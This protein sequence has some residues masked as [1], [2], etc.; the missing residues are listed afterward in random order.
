V[1]I[2]RSVFLVFASVALLLLAPAAA[3]QAPSA[4]ASAAIGPPPALVAFVPSALAT[5]SASPSA[6]AAPK[7]TPP[8]PSASGKTP[9]EVGPA[10]VKVHERDVFPIKVARGGQTAQARAVKASA[11]LDSALDQAEGDPEAR[12]EQEG[13]LAVIYVGKTPIVALGPEDA[14][15]EGGDTSLATYSGTIATR[16]QEALRIEKKRSAI[17]ETVFAFSLLVFS[18]LIAFLLLR[19]VGD[20]EEKVRAWVEANPE[21]LPAMRF[22]KIEIVSSRA[23]RGALSIS[24]RVGHRLAQV[25]IAYT[26]LIIA[27]SLFTATSG[28]TEKL[29]GFVVTPASSLAQRIG[30][31][32]PVLV[33]AILAALAVV[34]VV[35][36]VGLF[37]GS[38]ARGETKLS[39]LPADLADATSVIVRAGIV[40][41]SLVLASPLI[42]GTDEGALSH[43][44]VAT[45]I[46]LGLACTPVLACAAAGVPI[47]FGRR[48]RLGDFA[49]AGGRIGRV[50]SVTLLEIELEDSAGCEIRIPHLLGLW[51]PTRILGRALVVTIDVAVDPRADHGKVHETVLTAAKTISPRAKVDIVSIDSDAARYRITAPEVAGKNL[52]IAVAEALKGEA[53]S[54]GKRSGA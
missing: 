30:G 5:V 8:A 33:V 1:L 3:A 41:I 40:V 53:I 29:T 6:S 26:W 7:S 38:V 13:A 16:V 46:A 51:H 39:W 4:S 20:V 34:L 19:R 15:A 44:G 36:F 11:A 21:K 43:A 32:L 2:A 17:A 10:I 27:L 54:L 50:R 37:F 48:I 23:V 47:V 45:L 52:A 25:G 35:R 42:T 22:G 24:L 18:G 49:E 14:A 9:G 12:V 28:Y 31:A